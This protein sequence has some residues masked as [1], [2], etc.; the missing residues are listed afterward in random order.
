M[1]LGE[2][3]DIVHHYEKY[4]EWTDFGG[5]GRDHWFHLNDINFDIPMEIMWG[6]QADISV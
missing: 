2:Q 5:E 3:M 4:S 1:F 6:W